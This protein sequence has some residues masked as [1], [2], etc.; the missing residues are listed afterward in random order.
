MNANNQ[1][2]NHDS[3][4]ATRLMQHGCRL[5][6]LLLLVA[7]GGPVMAGSVPSKPRVIN[8]TDL[9]ADVDDQESLVRM[10]V[11]ANEY[12][13][14]GIIG[15]SSCWYKNQTWNNVT[16]LLNPILEAYGQVLT[17]LQV[18][19]EGYPSL[20]YLQSITKLGQP[21]Y[22]MGAVG[23]GLD[24][25]GS[26]MII[27]AADKDDPRPVWVNL[28]GGANT[29]AQ[30]LWKVQHTRTPEQLGQF[31]SKL[32]V[33]DVLGQDEAGAWIAKNF[34]NLVY[35]RFLG[36]YNWQPSDNWVVTNIQSK[37]PLGAV[38]PTRVWATEGDTPSF[39]Y[40]YPNGLSDSEHVDWGS[41]GGRCGPVKKVGVRSMSAV[42]G[43]AA[44]D[45]YYMY[46]D[47]P[48][49]GGSIGRW[50]TAINNDFAARMIW[51]V[52]NSY[53]GANHHPLA[54]L[55]GNTNKDI[56]QISAAPGSSVVL[57]AVGSGDP[58]GDALTY[59]WFVY[60]EPSSYT[61][62]VNI[63][64]NYSPTATVS[65][66]SD[67]TNKTI[68]V[69]LELHDN[70]SP[71]LYAY[72]RAVITMSPPATPG[73]LMVTTVSSNQLNLTWNTSSNATSYNLKRSTTAGG[74]YTVI[75]TNLNFTTFSDTN[76]A[77]S[78]TY[79]YVVSASSGL[80]SGDSTPATAMTGSALRLRVVI[81][82]D[83]PPTNVCLPS[84]GCPS[85]QTS[86]PDDVQSMVRWLLYVNEFD[87]EGMVASSGTFAGIANKSNILN[88]LDLYDQVYPNLIQHDLRYPTAN[89]L[90]AVTYQGRS[91]TWGGSVAN[92]IGAGKDSEASDAIIA[93]VDKPDP[94]P[95]WFCFW[96][97][98]SPLAQA[99]WKVQNT[100][101]AAELTNFLSKIRIHQIAH[102][103]DTIDWMMNNFP[104]L[105]IIYSH[106]TY[107]GIFGS[108]N[109]AWITTNI[110]QNHGPLGAV[111]PTAGI[112]TQT[113]GGVAEGDT[114]SYL[115]LVS[116]N[117]GLNN[118]EDPTQPS[119]GGQFNR[120]GTTSHYIDGPGG[121][122]ISMW[123]TQ[124]EAEFKQRANWML[125]I[126]TNSITLP[127][128]PVIGFAP[129]GVATQCQQGQNAQA[130]T[131]TVSNLGSG[132]MTYSV[133]NG[134]PW[135]TVTPTSGSSAGS[136][137][138]VAHTVNFNTSTLS[139]GTYFS[140]VTINAPGIA[141]PQAFV[142]VAVRVLANGTSTNFWN[143][144]LIDVGLNEGTGT[145][146]SNQG[147]AG[148][149]LTVS[150]PIPVWSS[151]VAHG[152]GGAASVD[153]GTTTGNYYVEST[154]NYPQLA[155]L[156]KFT[157]TG[158]VNC[159][160]NT[161]GSGGNRLVTWINSGGDGVDVV[162]KSDGSVM[163]GINQWPDSSPARSSAGKITTDANAG[164]SNWRFFAVTYDSTLASGQVKFYFGSSDSPA[165]LDVAKDYSR[166][167]VGTNISRFCIGH[168][169]ISF[170][171]SGQNRMFRGLIDEVQVYDQSLSLENIHAIQVGTPPSPPGIQLTALN[172]QWLLLTWTGANLTLEESP[173][174]IGP[175]TGCT[176][177]TGS[178]LIQPAAVKRFFRLE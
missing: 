147:S 74:P 116:A 131:L 162:Y 20:A 46:S 85:S 133:T 144:P 173:D 164:T 14:E 149:N 47:A 118:P 119:W 79:Y 117:R 166:G 145:A 94:R 62:S 169:N 174:V 163:V 19:A 17:N 69:V 177:Q 113:T 16:N 89:M 83:F 13:L 77:A 66:P 48:E 53:A 138:P 12:D 158:W 3:T 98:C 51:S 142:P 34:T 41:W 127:S 36:V 178:Q 111:Y 61:G 80:E 55:N 44:Y 22:S 67:T 123:K 65:I 108:D 126:S 170:R 84:G 125:P 78:T 32:R 75:A 31:V 25:P 161:E 2:T 109:L 92:N 148:G 95:V 151:N 99:I 30:A 103:D 73:G 39:L 140:W 157:V 107:Q 136:N 102:Q 122:S 143:T 112:A 68:H 33:Y 26:D 175:W 82:T 139:P 59:S 114:P 27:A 10:L 63:Q 15:V 153:F 28:W 11:T 124:Y 37:G 49:G 91:G 160:N 172:S 88:M 76:L 135:F 24:S 52:T 64:N 57:S 38:Y 110:I 165:T 97:D 71:H 21:G 150:T 86:D 155:G 54:V 56:L 60:S 130:K 1:K 87:V 171:N 23:A 4:T 81:S 105:F 176:N 50:S 43:E 100:R 120:D 156:T 58:D 128:A 132:S 154:T 42:T 18:H 152:V 72:R 168:F 70:G 104:S 101:S 9:G 35:I 115:L 6:V 141:E 167:A 90:R 146:A 129:A 7:W 29:V 96:G 5:V 134:A 8:T 159:R 106:T 137:N 121:S 45:P 93:I 40:E